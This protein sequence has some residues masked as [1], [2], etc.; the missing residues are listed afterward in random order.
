MALAIRDWVVTKAVISLVC[1]FGRGA[2]DREMEWADLT[3]FHGLQAGAKRYG[4]PRDHKNR[5]AGV[6]VPWD[7]VAGSRASRRFLRRPAIAE[8]RTREWAAV[9]ELSLGLL[10]TIYSVVDSTA[11]HHH[12]RTCN[13][14][15]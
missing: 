12:H 8:L 9:P 5:R 7:P 15:F 11:H 3:W 1:V 10:S 2:S 4:F 13:N 6:N 14:C